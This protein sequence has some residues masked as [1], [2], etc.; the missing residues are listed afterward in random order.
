M[1]G[2]DGIVIDPENEF[3]TLA[4]AVDG[5]FLNMSL[6]SPCT[7]TRL[8][9]PSPRRR[10]RRKRLAFQRHQLGGL[11]RILFGG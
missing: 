4:E 1:V 10:T 6:A 5:S 8:T 11:I 9:C 2:V 7:S 3:K